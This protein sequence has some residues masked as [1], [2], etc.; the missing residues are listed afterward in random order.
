[1]NSTQP[2][3][4]ITFWGPGGL[5][6]IIS[7]HPLNQGCYCIEFCCEYVMPHRIERELTDAHAK[8]F[9]DFIRRVHTH[10]RHMKFEAKAAEKANGPS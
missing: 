5:H 4:K 6:A 10:I 3:G 9:P 7:Q 1:M 2:S 8:L